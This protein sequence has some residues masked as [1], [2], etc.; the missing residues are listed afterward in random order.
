MEFE[1]PSLK[2]K[3]IEIG[4]GGILLYSLEASPEEQIGYSISKDGELLIG[5][6]DG[7]WLEGWYVIGRDLSLGDPI[8]INLNDPEIPVYT[9][10]HGMGSWTPEII[11]PSYSSF[12]LAL[13]LLERISIGRS[14]PVKLHSNPISEG[15][16]DKYLNEMAII[17]GQVENYFWSSYI[18]I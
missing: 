12:L 3:N 1:I 7:D 6:D 9:A 17:T 4:Y 8:F 2:S 10:S 5:F 18:G 16:S 15:E 13:G 14:T 11:A